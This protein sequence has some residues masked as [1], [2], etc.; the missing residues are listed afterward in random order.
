VVALSQIYITHTNRLLTPAKGGGFGMFS[1]V[2][3]LDNRVILIYLED[4]NEK[5]RFE[6]DQDSKFFER[7][8][9]N[10][11]KTAQSY[12][13]ESNLASLAQILKNI[14][15]FNSDANL[16][17]EVR[18]CVFDAKSN[19]ISYKLVHSLKAPIE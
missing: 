7:R 15:I 2:D 3:K 19:S 14:T 6:I 12:P 17:I 5:K 4:S 8:I 18:K 1:T 11:W 16:I 10:K 9:K 13:T